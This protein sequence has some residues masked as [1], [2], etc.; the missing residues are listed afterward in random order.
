MLIS[1]GSHTVHAVSGPSGVFRITVPPKA[2]PQPHQLEHKQ[3]LGPARVQPSRINKGNRM[4]DIMANLEE[5]DDWTNIAPRRKR[6]VVESDTEDMFNIPNKVEPNPMAPAK[7]KRC[8]NLEAGNPVHPTPPILPLQPPLPAQDPP[9]L[10]SNPKSPSAVSFAYP[11]QHQPPF[12]AQYQTEHNEGSPTLQDGPVQ[13]LEEENN[14]P[15]AG[16]E[17]YGMCFC[18]FS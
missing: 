8:K 1:N 3:P 7:K 18:F 17:D 9:T 16:E 15:D 4:A 13:E 5:D 2:L 12:S 10:R 6:R 11:S 14:P